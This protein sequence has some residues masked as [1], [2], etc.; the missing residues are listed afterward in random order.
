LDNK[1]LKTLEFNKII[2]K[3]K[4]YI[5]SPLG[6][7]YLNDMKQY[8]SINEIK[9]QL[10]ATSEA[11]HLITIG[12]LSLSGLFD[13]RNVLKQVRINSTPKEEDFVAI[14][15]TIDCYEQA[16]QK[17]RKQKE[18]TPEM[19]KLIEGAP[20]LGDLSNFLKNS[21]SPEGYVLDDASQELKALR[22]K[23]MIKEDNIK[24]RV[25]SIVQSSSMSTYLQEKLVTIR[26]GKYVIPVKYN[27][28]SQVKGIVHDQSASGATLFIEPQAIVELSNELRIL[29]QEEKREVDRILRELTTACYDDY[30]NLRFV[31]NIMGV[32]DYLCARGYL[33]L[34]MNAVE[35]KVNDN[36]VIAINN[37]RHPLIP[38]E[39]VVPVSVSIGDNYKSLIITGPNTGGKTVTLKLIGLCQVMAQSGLHIPADVNSEVA[40]FDNVL[41]DI[42]DEQ[43]IEQSLST[44]SSHMKNIVRLLDMATENSLVLLDELGAGTDP[45][46]G[47]ALAMSIID[48]LLERNAISV[49]TTHYSELKV[50]AY[51]HPNIING[52]VEF[53]IE[54]LSP[55]YKLVLG[56]PGKS[57]AFLI[58]E[59][60]GL[61]NKIISRA[62]S[63][64]TSEQKN[65]ESLIRD[66][67][68][69][70]N[71]AK[72]KLREAMGIKKQNEDLKKQLE[73]QNQII[74]Q[75]KANLKKTVYEEAQADIANMQEELEHTIRNLK[76]LLKE[77]LEEEAMEA[78]I[79]E[80]R[81]KFHETEDKIRSNTKSFRQP[82]IREISDN[83]VADWMP[84]KGMKILHKQWNQE[85][86]II[87]INKD[88]TEVQIQC[89]QMKFWT[90]KD[91]LKPIHENSQEVRR[92][93]VSRSSNYVPLEL[94]IR[95][96]SIMEAE[97]IIDKYLDNAV[98][99]GRSEV[100]IIHGKGT[101]VLRKGVQEYLMTHVHVE[102]IRL[103]NHDEGGHGVT[104]AKLSK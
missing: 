81:R 5:K 43:S 9:Y 32:L 26:Q 71:E 90:S 39:E 63:Y 77:S 19:N 103:G 87:D 97:E 17:I 52:S 58:S 100:A 78:I 31:I 25:D 94:D 40:I 8:N 98:L 21:I 42:G 61:P 95:G 36:K 74:K 99:S 41:A 65:V 104:I 75:E 35:P 53:D 29:K 85:G 47:A 80:S 13:I 86:Y 50:Y 38:K 24:K 44:F 82:I 84:Q 91:A 45:V 68:N 88:E 48:E 62:D 96:K 89:G 60:L 69:D 7:D 66:L 16:I 59:R 2:E 51:D 49:A 101:G 33:S 37:A 76:E 18:D 92:A 46:E 102:E 11:R 27:Y 73:E 70:R 30:E 72:R 14:Y 93:A 34:E 67:E 20:Y 57:N 12:K 23:I 4:S 64:L 56:V 1:S 55:T 6:E 15:Q 83:G 28:R 79:K 54:T 10:A 22:R 3:L